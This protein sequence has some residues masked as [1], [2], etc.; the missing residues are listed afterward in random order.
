VTDIALATK[1]LRACGLEW[2]VRELDLIDGRLA[3]RYHPA[4]T[5]DDMRA[6][7][8]ALAAAEGDSSPAVD[9]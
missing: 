3:I 8:N 1:R 2:A 5:V 6:V 4:A 9:P 7:A